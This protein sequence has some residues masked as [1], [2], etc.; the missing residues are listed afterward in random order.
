MKNLKF[1]ALAL[2]LVI[3][4]L[5]AALGYKLL[6]DYKNSTSDPTPSAP[7]QTNDEGNPNAVDFTVYD[8]KGN[9]VKLSDKRG[10][11]V[12]VNICATWCGYCVSEFPAF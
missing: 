11:P 6:T 5:A 1:I 2:A 3:V 10:K 7:P 9:A 12:V 8:S 4:I